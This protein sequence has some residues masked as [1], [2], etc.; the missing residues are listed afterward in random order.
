MTVNRSFKV[1][2]DSNNSIK[3]ALE[4]DNHDLEDNLQY[5]TAKESQCS[6]NH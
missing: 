1:I 3:L 4:L 6:L 5:I 2:S